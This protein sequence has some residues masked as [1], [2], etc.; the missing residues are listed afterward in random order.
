MKFLNYFYPLHLMLQI[1]KESEV[2]FYADE[3]YY[4][5]SVSGYG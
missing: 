5:E 4:S 1:D 2:T 3:T